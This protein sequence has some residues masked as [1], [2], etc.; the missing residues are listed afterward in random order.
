[1]PPPNMRR[2]I[3]N[4]TAAPDIVFPLRESAILLIIRLI[5]AKGI[6]TQLSQP[7]SGMNATSIRMRET[8]PSIALISFSI[9][10]IGVPVPFFNT[11]LVNLGSNFSFVNVVKL[12]LLTTLVAGNSLFCMGY[13]VAVDSIDATTKERVRIITHKV[14][15][16][17]YHKFG[18]LSVVRKGDKYKIVFPFIQYTDVAQ[19]YRDRRDEIIRKGT[20]INLKLGKRKT[21]TAETNVD[22]NVIWHYGWNYRPFSFR[23]AGENNDRGDYGGATLIV[24]RSRAGFDRNDHQHTFYGLNWLIEFEFTHDDM[25]LLSRR[26]IT[27]IYIVK[28]GRNIYLPLKNRQAAQIQHSIARILHK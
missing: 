2:R 4:R 27:D 19:T 8:I 13:K 15:D 6:T 12:F 5:T 24:D 10:P 22:I 3:P 7:S 26:K 23:S 25:L 11:I 20:K 9:A 18:K 1:M 28:N 16:A 21:V 14:G 17:D